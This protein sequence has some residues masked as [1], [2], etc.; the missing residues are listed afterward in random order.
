MF[1]IDTE[2]DTNT[3][4]DTIK[5]VEFNKDNIDCV[6]SFMFSNISAL[7]SIGT[8]TILYEENRPDLLSYNLYGDTQYWWVLMWYNS[9]LSINDLVNGLVISYPSLSSLENLY[10]RASTLAKTMRK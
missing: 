6:T 8:Y 5:F 7:P 9:L 10:T 3:R 1:Y 4:F 2:F